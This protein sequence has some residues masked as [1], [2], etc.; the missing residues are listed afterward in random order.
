MRAAR[1][2]L[3]L[4]QPT[5]RN[6][7][8]PQ[9]ISAQELSDS[10]PKNEYITAVGGVYIQPPETGRGILRA[11]VVIK[12]REFGNALIEQAPSRLTYDWLVWNS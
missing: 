1:S 9:N 4:A 10:W 8:K 5:R 6:P 7:S 12:V 2:I 3:I 11:L